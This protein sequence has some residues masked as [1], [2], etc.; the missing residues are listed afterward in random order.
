MGEII[1][2]TR[3]KITLKGEFLYNKYWLFVSTDNRIANL[4]EIDEKEYFSLLKELKSRKGFHHIVD[5][6]IKKGW[7]WGFYGRTCERAL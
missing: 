5:G 3:S 7:D 6:V 2:L 4:Q 1:A